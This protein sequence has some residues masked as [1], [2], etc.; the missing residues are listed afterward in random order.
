MAEH[1]QNN[2]TQWETSPKSSMVPQNPSHMYLQRN[3]DQ[4]KRTFEENKP[5]CREPEN[6][7]LSLKK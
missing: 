2:A 5:F 7:T 3:L 1:H 6:L 4:T